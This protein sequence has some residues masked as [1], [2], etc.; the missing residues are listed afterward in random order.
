M[1]QPKDA[2]YSVRLGPERT[3]EISAYAKDHGLKQHAA[4]LA[5]I[6]FGLRGDRKVKPGLQ[7][8]AGVKV[9][10]ASELLNPPPPPAPVPKKAAEPGAVDTSRYDEFMARKKADEANPPPRTDGWDP[11]LGAAPRRRD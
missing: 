11:K 9:R 8:P 10:P 5:L 7:L 1:A 4:V 6:D 2:P 3:A